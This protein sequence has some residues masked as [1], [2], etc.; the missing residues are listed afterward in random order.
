[1]RILKFGAIAVSDAARLRDLVAIVR[2][3]HQD[4]T[5][6]V[7]VCTALPGMTDMLLR[8]AR[9]AAHGDE[10]AIEVARRDLWSR[11]RAL[12]ERLVHDEWEREALYREWAELLKL[13][14]RV[15]R[16]IATLGEPSPRGSDAV[17]SLGERFVAHLVA[18]ALRQGGTPARVVDAA[19]LI[20]TD[21]HFGAARPFPQESAER[22]RERLLPM[23][24]AGIIPV[25]TGYIGATRGGVVTT[26][27]R[28]GGDY[29][30]AL[31]GAALGADEVTLWTDVSGILTADPK[32]V[33]G[34][35]TLATL[36][37]AEAAEIA[38]LGPEVLHPRAIGPVAARG[39][40]LRIRSVLR[41]DD[42][43]TRIVAESEPGVRGARA[44]ISTRDLRL[45]SVVVPGEN[46][47]SP[48]AAAAALAR[49]TDRGIE[50][51]SFALSF[52]ERSLVVAVRATDAEFARECL[53][54][55]APGSLA[56][57][58]QVVTEAHVGLLIVICAQA[59][60]AIAPRALASLAR[61][62]A[63]VLALARGV[64][65]PHLSLLLPDAEIA[66]AVR[67]L[68][69]ELGLG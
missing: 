69:Q 41:P 9:G 11:H 59:S 14:D 48:D 52:A 17:A 49:L 57:A 67:T 63:H 62:G 15:T 51:L 68:H 4:D 23:G 8:A 21:D 44:L 47:W 26:L 34:A 45:L 39:I 61:V 37:Y 24:Q 58:P 42:P 2:A 1:M 40:P 38:A 29:T 28:G 3:A 22:L 18:V 32:I 20:V 30:A 65:A 10:A 46:G 60:E 7:V 27:G 54:E 43:G 33:P 25:V 56:T 13:F 19:E 53:A 66:A 6:L 64:R 35:R 50:P 5:A 12:A 31:I 36:S 16:A 55:P